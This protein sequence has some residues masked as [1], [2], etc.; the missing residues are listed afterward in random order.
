MT[1]SDLLALVRVGAQARLNDI[2]AERQRLLRY[3]PGLTGGG[4]SSPRRRRIVSAAA[5]R[6]VSL[7]QKKRWAEWR[8]RK[9]AGKQK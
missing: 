1:R 3:F 4:S 9:A 2:D 5:R 8:K 6:A 7:A